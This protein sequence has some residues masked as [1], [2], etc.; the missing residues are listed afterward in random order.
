[1]E[2]S[3]LLLQNVWGLRADEKRPS[4]LSAP[5]G[6]LLM[7][8]FHYA[9]RWICCDQYVLLR[10]GPVYVCRLAKYTLNYDTC[11]ATIRRAHASALTR[12]CPGQTVLSHAAVGL[13]IWSGATVAVALT[14]PY[15]ISTQCVGTMQQNGRLA[16]VRASP[17]TNPRCCNP[18]I[19]K[20]R[21]YRHGRIMP[22]P[23]PIPR[24]RARSGLVSDTDW[25]LPASAELVNHFRDAS[26]GNTSQ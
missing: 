17:A 14:V 13:R 18:R 11:K 19:G 16:R 20:S 8:A 2:S 3:R 9:V 23:F 24:A 25:R 7:R 5:S 6:G 15:R 22:S 21:P 12:H 10:F 1:V 26:R 4:A